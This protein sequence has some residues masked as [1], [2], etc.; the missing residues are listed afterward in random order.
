MSSI[1]EALRDPL[2]EVVSREHPVYQFRVAGLETLVTVTLERR[3]GRIWYRTSHR[4]M[5]PV[6]K[7]PYFSSLPHAREEGDALK[8]AVGGLTIWFGGAIASGHTPDESW[9]VPTEQA[10]AAVGR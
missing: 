6:Q 2:I 10:V 1:D 8:D 9:L 3:G 7:T 4:T 5:T